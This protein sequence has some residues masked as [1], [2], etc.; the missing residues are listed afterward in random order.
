MAKAFMREYSSVSGPARPSAITPIAAARATGQSLLQ[1]Q[2]LAALRKAI[3]AKAQLI[4]KQLLRRG[5][6]IHHSGILLN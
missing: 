5:L 4:G 3:S 2:R 6:G 1:R